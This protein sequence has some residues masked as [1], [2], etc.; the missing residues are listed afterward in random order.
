MTDPNSSLFDELG[1]E[2]PLRKIVDTFVDRLCDDLMIG[3]HFSRVDRDRLKQLEYEF[4]ARHLGAEVPYTGRSLEAAHRAHRIFDGQ[5]SRRLKLLSDVL[6]EAGAPEAVR[7]HW[8]EHT[9]AQRDHVVVG[10]C[11]DETD[12]TGR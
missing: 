10:A 9:L 7:K 3:F 5:F 4:A 2:E 12:R 6:E 8:L 1:G 11:I